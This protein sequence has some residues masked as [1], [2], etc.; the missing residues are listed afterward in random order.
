M[1]ADLLK[2]Q[3]VNQLHRR[4]L[5]VG[6]QPQ[7]SSAPITPS[8]S[9]ISS[10]TP[11]ALSAPTL[12]GATPVSQNIDPSLY[13]P[14]DSAFGDPFEKD[15]SPNSTLRGNFDNTP[16]STSTT[17]T[18]SPQ[19]ASGG[20]DPFAGA[21]PFGSAQHPQH[22]QQS[23]LAFDPFAPAYGDTG[24]KVTGSTSMLNFSRNPQQGDTRA[25]G[26]THNRAV[27]YDPAMLGP[28]ENNLFK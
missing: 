4:N 18:P 21:S 6:S 22:P 16:T 12:L 15:P 27:S 13:F 10:H 14:D 19:P 8:S 25:R 23:P 28:A 20:F 24:N 7:K 17:P 11:T 3:A 9:Y 1:K 5:S 26:R 2:Q